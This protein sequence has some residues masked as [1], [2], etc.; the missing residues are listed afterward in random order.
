MSAGDDL[1]LLYFI[2]SDTRSV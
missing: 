2:L 1:S